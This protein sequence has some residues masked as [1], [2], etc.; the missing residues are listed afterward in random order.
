MKE[1]LCSNVRTFSQG[2]DMLYNCDNL[3]IFF[4][5]LMI[6]EQDGYERN[7]ETRESRVIWLWISKKATVLLTMLS[8][9]MYL[10]RIVFW[11]GL[12]SLC[13]RITLLRFQSW[14]SILSQMSS[15]IS[16]GKFYTLIFCKFVRLPYF[17]NF[18]SIRLWKLRGGMCRRKGSSLD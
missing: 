18:Q 13:C 5:C 14:G 3:W 9:V 7:M 2:W 15:L 4:E 6:V 8:I 11:A 16:L 12:T 10:A 17:I 1:I